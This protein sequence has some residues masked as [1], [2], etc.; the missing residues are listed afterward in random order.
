[1]MSFYQRVDN[2]EPFQ[3]GPRETRELDKANKQLEESPHVDGEFQR[4]DTV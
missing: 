1:M 2:T 3:A 4:G